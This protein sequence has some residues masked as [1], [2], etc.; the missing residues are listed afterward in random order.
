MS[1]TNSMK[2]TQGKWEGIADLT[3]KAI[4]KAEVK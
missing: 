2:H 4:D 3:N 1:N